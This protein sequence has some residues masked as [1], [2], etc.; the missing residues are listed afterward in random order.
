LRLNCRH[1]RAQKPCAGSI[2]GVFGT[3]GRDVVAD[4]VCLDMT[5]R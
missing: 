2:A 3:A 1:T 5:R 4:V